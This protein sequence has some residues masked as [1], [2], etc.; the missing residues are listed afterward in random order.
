MKNIDFILNGIP[1]YN[2]F[3]LVHDEIPIFFTCKDNENNFY[4]ALCIDMDLPRYNVVQITIEQLHN[5]LNGIISMKEIFTIQKTYWEVTSINEN[6]ENDIVK[7]KSINEINEKDLP[8]D[9]AYF[10]LYSAELKKYDEKIYSHLVHNEISCALI[11]GNNSIIIEPKCPSFI[12]SNSSNTNWLIQY[13]TKINKDL[14]FQSANTTT[15]LDFVSPL[16]E[17]SESN[18][19]NTLSNEKENNAIV[20]NDCIFNAKNIT[21]DEKII[22]SANKIFFPIAA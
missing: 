16:L 4:L 15:N 18:I 6:V 8:N 13:F 1:V 17:T 20:N 14:N 19:H 7:F 10:E 21:I 5:M 22:V 9:D 3:C 12:N 2:D 11:T